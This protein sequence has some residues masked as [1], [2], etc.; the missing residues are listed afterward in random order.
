MLR[1]EEGGENEIHSGAKWKNQPEVN[2]RERKTEK[3]IKASM[4]ETK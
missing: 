4:G 2:K 1:V 3:I